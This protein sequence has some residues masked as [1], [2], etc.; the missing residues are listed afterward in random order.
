M[1]RAQR[2]GLTLIELAIALA[3]MALL[4]AL[5]VPS[6]GAHLDQRRLVAAAETLAA[7]MGEAR[8]EAARQGRP[9]HLLVQAGS[10]WCWSVASTPHCPCGQRQAC[11]LRSSSANDHGAV[12]VLQ[13]QGM[14]PTGA[15][16]S[17]AT[18]TLQSRRGARLQ[19]QLQALGRPR[20]CSEL[21]P[22]GRYPSC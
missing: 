6:M 15:A 3:L 11:E 13:G 1:K 12:Q 19:V 10:A 21:G 4:A 8:F 18:V 20:I 7:D 9:M 2:R 22:A 5:A 17:A 16:Q 14:T